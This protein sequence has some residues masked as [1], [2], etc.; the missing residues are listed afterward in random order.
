MHEVAG[1]TALRAGHLQFVLLSQGLPKTLS[2]TDAVKQLHKL[3]PDCLS[4]KHTC[5]CGACVPRM[6]PY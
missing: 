1:G 2:L 6:V 4:K 5:R 3:C